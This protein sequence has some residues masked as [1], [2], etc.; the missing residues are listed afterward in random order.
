MTLHGM[1]IEH[2]L[3]GFLL[4]GT[5]GHHRQELAAAREADAHQ[6]QRP[7]TGA[8]QKTVAIPLSP[9]FV[10]SHTPSNR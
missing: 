7:H 1:I 8:Q 4:A 6:V 10:S 9:R 2:L 3:P 5:R